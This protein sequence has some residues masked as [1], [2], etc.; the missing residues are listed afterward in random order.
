VNPTLLIVDDEKTQREGLRA[1]LEHRYDVYLAEDVK[2]A[3]DLLERE[4][5][6]VLLTDFRLPTKDGLKLI[7]RFTRCPI[8]GRR[9]R[10]SGV[11]CRLDKSMSRPRVNLLRQVHCRRSSD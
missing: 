7:A 9:P 2:S 1:A 6:D 5:F 11:R 4:K 3:T 8:R 10:L